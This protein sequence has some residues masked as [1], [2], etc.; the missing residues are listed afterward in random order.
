MLV[1]W[2]KSGFHVGISE[3]SCGIVIFEVTIVTATRS[4]K[5]QRTSYHSRTYSLNHLIN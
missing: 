1:V 4:T 2:W 5:L 3:C